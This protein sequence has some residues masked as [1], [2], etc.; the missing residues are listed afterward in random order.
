MKDENCRLFFEL[1]NNILKENTSDSHK[2]SKIKCWVDKIDD[3]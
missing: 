2:I 1:V 3:I